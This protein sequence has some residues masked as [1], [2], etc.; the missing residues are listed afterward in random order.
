VGTGFSDSRMA[1]NVPEKREILIEFVVNGNAVK[2]T[3]IDAETG[4]EAS[5]V[6][7]ASAAREALAQGAVRKLKYLLDKMR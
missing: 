1:V 7:P 6:G 3:A 5:I 4:V 2:A